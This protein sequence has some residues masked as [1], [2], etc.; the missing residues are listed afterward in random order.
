MGSTPPLPYRARPPLVFLVVGA[1]LL[2]SGGG[3]AAAVFGA[4]P[5]RVLLLGLAGIAAAGSAWG[6]AHRLRG[7]EETFAVA[8]VV[9]A[10][11]GA[12]AAGAPVFSG[13]VVP[14]AVLTG[15]FLALALL[16]R[17]PATWPLAAW[18]AGQLAVLRGL[19]GMEAGV[20][21]T[22]WLLGV[23]VVGLLVALG[24]R[25]LVARVALLSTAPW[26]VTGVVAAV[27]TAWSGDPADRWASAV[28]T[29]L[30]AAVLLVARL[31]ADLEPLLGPPVAVPVLAGVAVGAAVG[32]PLAFPGPGGVMLAGYT[33]VVVASVAAA[34]LTGWPR[35]MLLPLAVAAGGTLVLVS[36]VQLVAGA[37]WLELS[38][39][40]LLTAVPSALVAARRRDERPAAAPTTVG[41]L[42]G[43]A[44]FAIAAGALTPVAAAVVLSG[45]YAASLVIGYVLDAD[46]RRATLVAGA[47][48]AAGAVVLLVGTR[49]RG[50]L[51]VL[52]AEQGVLTC[53]WA[54][55]AWRTTTPRPDPPV[56]APAWRAGAAQLVVAAWTAVGLAGWSVLEAYTLPLAAGLLL[57]AGPRLI[58]GPSWPAWGPALLVAAVPSVV[59]SVVVPNSPR[60]VLVIVVAAL[61]MLY[62]VHTGARAPLVAG[63][64]TELAMAGGL[65]LVALPWPVS[66][67]LVVGSA[68][69]ALG[70]WRE[71]LPVGWWTRRLAD[72]R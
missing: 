63:S 42:A 62:G 4:G 11:L 18:A 15:V 26:W 61:A 19:Q 65:G 22:A 60:P 14:L 67:A 3:T 31:E 55:H 28:L 39:L 21:R 70:A 23:A 1:A 35:G 46:S 38:L 57:A 66:T 40:L 52:L 64:G 6:S 27:V 69:A 71:R 29:A 7:T 50:P 41:C 59:W 49:E 68:L 25:R 10:V 56:S 54:W 2:V 58:A 8:A 48:C 24:G 17:R 9:L 72:M 43:A 13:S 12:G 5:A 47:V 20:A 37:R 53:A 34:L 16:L 30:A 45:L 36:V 51:A 32:G 33:G 44:V